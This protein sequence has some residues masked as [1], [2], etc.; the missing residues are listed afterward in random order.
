MFLYNK[1]PTD[2]VESNHRDSKWK[3]W[4]F[5]YEEVDTGVKFSSYI[6]AMNVIKDFAFS[7]FIV[8]GVENAALQIIP[9][10]VICFALSIFVLL[11]KPFKSKLANWTLI[12]NNI[13][14]TIV[15]IIFYI[16]DSHTGDKTQKDRYNRHGMIAV[17][18]IGLIVLINLSIGVITMI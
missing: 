6:I 14:Y 8:L 17:V 5:L 15:L 12:L 2:K 4:E 9:L 18:F 16:I 1:K 3:K 13:N 7:P 11:K 10:A